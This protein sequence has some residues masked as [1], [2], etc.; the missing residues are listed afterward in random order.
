MTTTATPKKPGPKTEAGKATSCRNAVTHGIWSAWVDESEQAAYDALHAQLSQ[1]YAELGVTGKIMIERVAVAMVR[2]N[3]LQR[4]EDAQYQRARLLRAHNESLTH[5][6]SI[7]SLLPDDDASR[8]FAVTLA[9]QAALPDTA[10]LDSLARYDTTLERQVF[11]WLQALKVLKDD[12]GAAAPKPLP[13][14]EGSA[15]NVRQL[16]VTAKLIG[17][18]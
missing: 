1:E 9:S 3:R 6:N 7:S 15:S 4:V 14:P 16:P 13:R 8:Q 10:N 18:E 12:A 2:L 17:A 5:G 11:K